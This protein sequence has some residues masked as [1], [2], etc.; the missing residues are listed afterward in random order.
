MLGRMIR[1]RLAVK[2]LRTD[3]L[4]VTNLALRHLFYNK[5]TGE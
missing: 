2:G 3:M 1:F 4:Q 5:H